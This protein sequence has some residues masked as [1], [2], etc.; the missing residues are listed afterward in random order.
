MH[1]SAEPPLAHD[2]HSLHQHGQ[3]PEARDPAPPQCH[4]HPKGLVSLWGAEAV[5]AALCSRGVSPFATP[6]SLPVLAAA[7]FPAVSPAHGLP[8][9]T[10]FT[11]SPPEALE[12]TAPRSWAL[13][14][15]SPAAT[16]HYTAPPTS[17]LL[18]PPC[19]LNAPRALCPAVS[20]GGHPKALHPLMPV[21]SR[22]GRI[23]LRGVSVSRRPA[24]VPWRLRGV[25]RLR[26]HGDGKHGPRPSCC[27][28]LVGGA[29]CVHT[30][31][32]RTA[33]RGRGQ[34]A[35]LVEGAR[36]WPEGRGWG[37]GAWLGQEGVKVHGLAR[38]G[39][40]DRGCP[41]PVVPLLQSCHQLSCPSPGR[42]WPGD[43]GVPRGSWRDTVPCQGPAQPGWGSCRDVPCTGRLGT[44]CSPWL[45]PS[46]LTPAIWVWPSG[47]SICPRDPQPAQGDRA[48]W[49]WWRLAGHS[50]SPAAWS[51]SPQRQ[52]SLGPL[53]S[54]PTDA[55]QK[56]SPL[57]APARKLLFQRSVVCAAGPPPLDA[58]ASVFPGQGCAQLLWPQPAGAPSGD[59]SSLRVSALCQA[60]ASLSPSAMQL[61]R[62]GRDMPQSSSLAEGAPTM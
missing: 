59:C 48:G 27:C 20:L 44:R 35:G 54:I 56:K 60:G 62:G 33:W 43:T 42:T 38:A 21:P 1:P 26:L 9:M 13:L 53:A 24:T 7:P 61:Q 11:V 32:W 58:G 5:P 55:G 29:A 28:K 12:G 25:K 47:M 51:S 30:S 23:R 14:S 18:A 8:L 52:P 17:H 15:T 39:T 10:P 40:Q 37:K 16:P 3:G 22:L 36:S 41:R 57:I 4:P 50:Q 2:V 46:R 34:G 49:A 45:D 6:L 19:P 31:H